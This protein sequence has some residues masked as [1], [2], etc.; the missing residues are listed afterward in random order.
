VSAWDPRFAIFAA[1]FLTM[2]F[3]TASAFFFRFWRRTGDDFF[4][5]FA[6][7]FLLMAANQGIPV[8][9]NIPNEEQAGMYLLRLAAYGA[10]IVAIL[11]KNLGSGRG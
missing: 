10:I 11:R 9:L 8:L 1:G 7:A 6:V 5:T 4:A 3:L 2:G